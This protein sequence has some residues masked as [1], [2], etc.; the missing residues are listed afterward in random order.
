MPG[1]RIKRQ[2]RGWI[3]H[4]FRN[5]KI[6][7]RAIGYAVEIYR[8][9]SLFPKEEIYG[10]TSQIR[11]AVVSIALNIAEGSGNNSNKEFQRYLEIALRSDY[12]VIA[13]LEIA[14]RLEYFTKKE[15]ERLAG[16]GDEL[17]A[18]IAGFAKSLSI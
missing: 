3:K 17:A 5:L 16:E 2:W 8:L 1:A 9:S 4:N 14:L 7:Q 12:E 18:M 13:C 6:Y 11:R 10:L 15:F